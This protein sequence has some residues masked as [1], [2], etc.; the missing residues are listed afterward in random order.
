MHH[1]REE[2][3]GKII[4]AYDMENSTGIE[5]TVACDI[6]VLI[7]SNGVVEAYA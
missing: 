1:V 2:Q 7:F 5:G 4:H 3:E 6:A